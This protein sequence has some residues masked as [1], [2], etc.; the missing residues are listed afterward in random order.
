MS[1]R[2]NQK[3]RK[4]WIT[5]PCPSIHSKRLPEDWLKEQCCLQ[6]KKDRNGVQYLYIP[7][8][9]AERNL[10]LHRKRYGGKQFRWEYG[11]TDRLCMYGLWQIEAIRNIGYAALV[12]GEAIPVHV[13]H[14]NQHTRN[15]GSVHDA[16]R[17]GRS[18]AGFETLHSCRA[19]Q[20]RGSVPRQSHKGTPEGKFVGEVYKWSCRT[21]GCRAI[22]SLYE[23]WQRGS[24][25][26]DPKSNQQRRADRHRGR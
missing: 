16:G 3:R 25:R 26:E 17:L 22:G 9:D 14:G 7:Y 21:L 24:G 8:F 19:G 1:R 20:R 11:K 10:A 5:T 4:D 13:V 15:T 18:P 12:E 6:T 2:R 23:V